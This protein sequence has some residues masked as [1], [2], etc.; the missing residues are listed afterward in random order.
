MVDP[1][2]Y[3]FSSN[4]KKVLEHSRRQFC[5]RAILK[6]SLHAADIGSISASNMVPKPPGLIQEH[7]DMINL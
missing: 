4:N 5:A 2:L 6:H 7:R 1:N 3:N